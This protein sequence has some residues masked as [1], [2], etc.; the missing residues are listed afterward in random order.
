MCYL[1]LFAL[2]SI[3]VRVKAGTIWKNSWI[4]RIGRQLG[5]GCAV[6][7]DHMSLLWKALVLLGIYVVAAVDERMKSERFKT[8]LITNVSHDIKTPLTSIINYVDLLEKEELSNATAEEYL[9]VLE[10]QSGRS[11]S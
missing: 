4:Y 2:L 10:R 3:A 1:A 6:L 9:E 11:K 5:R 7:A 8:E